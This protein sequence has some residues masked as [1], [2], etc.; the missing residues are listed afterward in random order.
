MLSKSYFSVRF[1]SNPGFVIS[2][3]SL[4]TIK[5][6]DCISSRVILLVSFH[7]VPNPAA[8]GTSLGRIFVIPLL[9]GG[10]SNPEAG[11]SWQFSSE[12]R[13]QRETL[14]L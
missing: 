14:N 11:A 5:I 4:K 6:L 7:L 10:F 1:S 9:A 8:G 2:N 3:S 13:F 12:S